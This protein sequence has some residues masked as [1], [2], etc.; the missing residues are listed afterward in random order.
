[1]NTRNRTKTEPMIMT[2]KLSHVVNVPHL[3]WEKRNYKDGEMGSEKQEETEKNKKKPCRQRQT[4][5]PKH[6]ERKTKIQG[7]TQ[8]HRKR[9]KQIN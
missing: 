3:I 9:Q 5:S 1:M 4:Q 8:R 7:R 6:R 2:N